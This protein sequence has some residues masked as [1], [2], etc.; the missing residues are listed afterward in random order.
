MEYINNLLVKNGLVFAFV[1]TGVIMY[2]AIL[3]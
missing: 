3:L 2:L 1:V